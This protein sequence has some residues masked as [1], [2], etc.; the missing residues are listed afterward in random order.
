MHD[1]YRNERG[2]LELPIS[3]V[4]PKQTKSEVVR[5]LVEFEQL[6]L[7]AEDQGF[8]RLAQAV[9]APE[10]PELQSR[11]GADWDGGLIS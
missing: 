5:A 8:L 3:S 11:P 1:F 9:F 2:N 7:S 4:R 10:T 6:A